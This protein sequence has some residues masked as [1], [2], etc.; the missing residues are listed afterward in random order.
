M[1]TIAP[2]ALVVGAPRIP[3]PYGL[4]SVLSP[5]SGAADRWMAGGVI[6]ESLTCDELGGFGGVD[7][8]PEEIQGLP[9]EL[10]TLSDELGSASD[11]GVYGHWTCTPVG[12]SMEYAYGRA[13]AHLEAR[14]EGR[15]EQAL[16]TGDLGNTPNFA[17]A[18]DYAAPASVGSVAR[19]EAWLAVALLEQ[20]IAEA[21][22]SQGVL[23]MSREIAT[24]LFSD[25]K[26]EKR[27]G[28]LYTPLDTPVIAGSGYGSDKIVITPG[29]FG[30]RSEIF[31]GQDPNTS[32]AYLDRA[33]N[34]LT[35]LAERTYLLGFDPCGLGQVT[36]TE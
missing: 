36:L 29:L 25:G 1:P 10:G 19:D 27:G 16:W 20:H 18:N 32:G 5:R 12:N 13:T 24:I 4:F 17:G 31:P 8:D 7:C 30:Y 15:V 28:R 2:P 3:L 23:H 9:K 22:G 26:L 14:E 35:A 11:F 6:W 33:Q 34:N 21:Y